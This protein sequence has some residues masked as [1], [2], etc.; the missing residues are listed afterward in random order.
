ML[1]VRPSS[2]SLFLFINMVLVRF[3]ILQDQRVTL[4]TILVFFGEKEI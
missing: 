3:W 2:S 1:D 4:N